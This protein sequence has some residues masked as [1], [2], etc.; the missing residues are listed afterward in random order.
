VILAQS[1]HKEEKERSQEKDMPYKTTQKSREAV[2]R[3]RGWPKH[4]VAGV[5]RQ[6]AEER[7]RS[8]IPG[9]GQGVDVERPRGIWKGLH[10]AEQIAQG[11]VGRLK[12]KAQS[13]YK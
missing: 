6:M 4:K 1:I 3:K 13:K 8:L 10:K 7:R 12:K 11:N 5:A 2:A 9:V